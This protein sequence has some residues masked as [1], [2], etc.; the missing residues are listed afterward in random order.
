MKRYFTAFIL[1]ILIALTLLVLTIQK[2]DSNRVLKSMLDIKQPR[3]SLS[4]IKGESIQSPKPLAIYQIIF[5]DAKALQRLKQRKFSGKTTAEIKFVDG[6]NALHVSGSSSSVLFYEEV[7]MDLPEDATMQVEWRPGKYPSNKKN[8]YLGSKQDNDFTCQIYLLFKSGPFI[9]SSDIMQY[10][11]D[12]QYYEGQ[13]G[14]SDYSNKVKLMVIDSR[15]TNR[16]SMEWKVVT[17][18]IHE[19]YQQLFGKDLKYR[20]GGIGIMSDSDN[21]NSVSGAY[22]RNLKI[23]SA[24]N[25]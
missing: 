14:T 4:K 17:R 7:D 25:E 23:L 9:S 19:D 24:T 6:K 13:N 20:L 1:S 8:D 18:N 11:M 2:L 15:V 12:D 22:I 3:S 10:L 21:T 16:N 5:D